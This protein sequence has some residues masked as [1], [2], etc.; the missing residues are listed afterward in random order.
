MPRMGAA[1]HSFKRPAYKSPEPAA[2]KR[3]RSHRDR[4]ETESGTYHQP[5]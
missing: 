1:E 5:L 3:K 4:V 2:K